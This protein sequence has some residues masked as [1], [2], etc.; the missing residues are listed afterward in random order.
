M[1]QP[2]VPALAKCVPVAGISVPKEM[3]LLFFLGS[4]RFLC[5]C[6]QCL[7]EREEEPVLVSSLLAI[8][9]QPLEVLRRLSY[10]RASV[11]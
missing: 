6:L 10:P 3:H 7:A 2:A 4:V 9:G 5:G 1:L 11:N 8:P